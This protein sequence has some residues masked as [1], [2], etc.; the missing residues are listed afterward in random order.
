MGDEKGE[1]L[2]RWRPRKGWKQPSAYC[3]ITG[4]ECIPKLSFYE[5]GADAM[6]EA[7]RREAY[8]N[9]KDMSRTG[10]FIFIPD[11]GVK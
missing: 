7:L 2:K 1:D 4:V 11:D 3:K 5:A 8:P 10:V 9:D 6:L